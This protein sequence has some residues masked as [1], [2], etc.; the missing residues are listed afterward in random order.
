[1]ANN[2]IIEPADEAT[3][4][5]DASMVLFFKKKSGDIR[6]CIGLFVLNVNTEIEYFSMGSFNY[7]LSQFRTVKLL[8]IPDEMLFFDKYV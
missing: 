8:S 6:I 2:G 3:E 5:C 1:M 4:W 7:T